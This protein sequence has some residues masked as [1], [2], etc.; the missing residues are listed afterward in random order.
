MFF[1]NFENVFFPPDLIFFSFTRSIH[2]E[3]LNTLQIYRNLQLFTK[4]LPLTKLVV[5]TIR[6]FHLLITLYSLQTGKDQ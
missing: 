3:F 2:G 6:G 4:F 5:V 1:K